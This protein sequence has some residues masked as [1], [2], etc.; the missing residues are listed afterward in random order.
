MERPASPAPDPQDG[1]PPRRP[2]L[3]VEDHPVNVLLMSAI[4]ERRP[5]LQLVTATTGE[6]A[7]CIATGMNPVLLLLDLRLPDCHGRH[8]LA[9]LRQVA[10]CQQAP[11]VAVTADTDFELAG[12]GFDAMWLKPLRLEQVLAELDQLTGAEA[13]ARRRVP[14]RE[15]REPRDGG[16]PRAGPQAQPLPGWGH[17]PQHA[18]R[19]WQADLGSPFNFLSQG[20]TA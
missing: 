4:F 10:G 5:G 1:G 6:Q 17:G 14:G 11:A 7:L 3:Y 15:P 8:L 18:P 9:L 19:A 20:D 2:V 12:S 16:D 13:P